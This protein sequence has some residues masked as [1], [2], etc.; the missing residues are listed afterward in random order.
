MA[1]KRKS[2]YWTETKG[3]GLIPILFCGFVILLLF[4][5]E[6]TSSD[7]KK[8][9]KRVQELNKAAIEAVVGTQRDIDY[10]ETNFFDISDE[11]SGDC[12]VIIEGTKGT[13]ELTVSCEEKEDRWIATKAFIR[14]K[15]SQ[16]QS[17]IELRIR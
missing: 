9:L 3:C 7:I 14:Q 10:S 6:A 13:V 16:E 2:V 11:G 15:G 8:E 1:V 17:T 12:L 4:L 5:A